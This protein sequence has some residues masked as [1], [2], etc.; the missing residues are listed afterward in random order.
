MSEGLVKDESVGI[1][2]SH[3]IKNLIFYN[4]KFGL[5]L[6]GKRESLSRFVF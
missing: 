5:F 6:G 4:R 2:T 1:C 3:T